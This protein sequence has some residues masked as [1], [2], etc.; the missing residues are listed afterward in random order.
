MKLLADE[1][2]GILAFPKHAKDWQS[3]SEFIRVKD[4]E[5]R[6]IVP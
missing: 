5:D 4:A 1:N 2:I 3:Y 6:L